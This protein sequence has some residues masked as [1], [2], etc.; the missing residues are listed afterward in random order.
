M[1][2]EYHHNHYVPEW[3]QRRFIDSAELDQVLYYLNLEPEIFVDPRGISHLRRA[4]QKTGTK[5][6]FAKDDLYTT[7]FG[8]EEESTQIEQL[9]F[10]QIDSNGRKAVD[11]FTNF[12]QKNA[13]FLKRFL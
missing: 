3:Y 13:H 10:G 9:F 6:C 12:Q 2:N 8:G 7:T 1:S 11:Y 4:L 5:Q